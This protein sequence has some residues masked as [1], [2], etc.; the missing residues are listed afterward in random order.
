MIDSEEKLSEKELSD[1]KESVSAF[2]K[3]CHYYEDCTDC[4]KLKEARRRMD[5]SRAG[6]NAAIKTLSKETGFASEYGNCMVRLA[7]RIDEVSERA[8]R[9]KSFDPGRIALLLSFMDEYA[10]GLIA[11]G[12]AGCIRAPKP[13]SERYLYL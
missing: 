1:A 8:I 11:P 13:L 10:D 3:A 2:G 9:V 6:F 12:D 4:G 5:G 7:A